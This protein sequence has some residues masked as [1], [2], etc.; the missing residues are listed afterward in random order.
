MSAF[1]SLFED[2][3][4]VNALRSNEQKKIDEGIFKEKDVDGMNDS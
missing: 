1:F 2:H 4:S 3:A